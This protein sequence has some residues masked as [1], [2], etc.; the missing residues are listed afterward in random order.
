M[1]VKEAQAE[2]NK[3]KE[4]LKSCNKDINQKG[5]EQKDYQKEHHSSQLKVQELEHK[6]SKFQADSK[7]ATRQ[8]KLR[9]AIISVM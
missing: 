5:S 1:E 2:L 7:A 9:L 3:Q 4:L 8:V 6:M